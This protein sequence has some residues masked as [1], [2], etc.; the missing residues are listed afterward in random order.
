[1]IAT[2]RMREFIPTSVMPISVSAARQALA[3]LR[4]FPC[5]VLPAA[6]AFLASGFIDDIAVAE[7]YRGDYE[8]G[9]QGVE[10]F[11]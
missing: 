4:A 2:E 8:E 5:D 1:M 6:L 11:L 7:L 9:G 3:D 10:I